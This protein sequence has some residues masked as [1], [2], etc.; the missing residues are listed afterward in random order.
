MSEHQA[1]GWQGAFWS[2]LILSIISIIVMGV[3]Y[4]QKQNELRQQQAAYAEL[5]Q[6]YGAAQQNTTCT[7]AGGQGF[8]YTSTTCG[9]RQ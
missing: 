9:P 8:F 3:M 2:V 5:K 1:N 6:A 7:T 4:H